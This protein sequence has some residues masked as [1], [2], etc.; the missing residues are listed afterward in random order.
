M[1]SSTANS[2]SSTPAHT[3]PTDMETVT[4]PAGTELESAEAAPSADL[5]LADTE[6]TD[7]ETVTVRNGTE[8]EPAQSD[9]S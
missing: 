2:E 7:L 1:D 6:P 3:E 5:S 4:S 9:P 8:S